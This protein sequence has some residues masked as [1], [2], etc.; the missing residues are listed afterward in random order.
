MNLRTPTEEGS[1]NLDTENDT[2][3][4]GVHMQPVAK[5]REDCCS[6]GAKEFDREQGIQM[7]SAPGPLGQK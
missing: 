6:T 3:A 7:P 5:Q 1:I 4:I 2:I